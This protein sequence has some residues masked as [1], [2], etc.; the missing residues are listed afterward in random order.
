MR[1]GDSGFTADSP[2]D[3]E[4]RARA[5]L[6]VNCSH[7]HNVRGFAANTGFY[8]DSMRKV[9]QKLNNPA[10]AQKV[11]PHVLDEHQKRLADWQAKKRQVQAMLDNLK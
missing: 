3:I 11:P 6:E 7:C 4:A 2:E 8:L 10:F 9:E 5:Y 1:P